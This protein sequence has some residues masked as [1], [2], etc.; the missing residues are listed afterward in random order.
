M[1]T[2]RIGYRDAFGHGVVRPYLVLNVTGPTGVTQTIIG[3]V[4]SGADMTSLPMGFATLLG[5]TSGDLD[6]QQGT[7]ANGVMNMWVANKPC[8]AIVPELPDPV[9]EVTPCFL[10]GSQSPLWGRCDLFQAFGVGFDEQAQAFTL[11]RP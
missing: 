7:Q 10:A 1:P 6:L 5:Y 3:L 9:F 4:D 11:S 2:W 8:T